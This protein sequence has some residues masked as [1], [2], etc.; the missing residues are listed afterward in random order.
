[1]DSRRSRTS[2]AKQGQGQGE[3]GE[4]GSSCLAQHSECCP[5]PAKFAPTVNPNFKQII[6]LWRLVKPGPP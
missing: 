4:E 2:S 6:C 1:M 3:E 5:I